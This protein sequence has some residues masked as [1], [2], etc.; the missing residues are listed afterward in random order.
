MKS[1]VIITTANTVKRQHKCMY[2]YVYFLSKIMTL[3][4]NVYY[5][6]YITAGS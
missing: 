6:Q 2:M 5:G 1:D 4:Y 3:R